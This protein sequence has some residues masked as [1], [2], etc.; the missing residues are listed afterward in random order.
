ME[1]EKLYHVAL[2]DY[3][4]GI[5]IRT[6]NDKKTDLMNEGKSTD[7]IDDLIVKVGTAPQKKF[8]VI[9]ERDEAR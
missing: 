8:K 9:K 3:E 4:H 1:R 2:D 6:L 5:I 7:A